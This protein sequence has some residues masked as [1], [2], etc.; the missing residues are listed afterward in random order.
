MYGE[1][2]VRFFCM[3]I[4]TRQKCGFGGCYLCMCCSDFDETK[5]IRLS[6]VGLPMKRRTV[7]FRNRAMRSLFREDRE[8]FFSSHVNLKNMGYSNDLAEVDPAHRQPACAHT[9]RD[10]RAVLFRKTKSK[11]CMAPIHFFL[12]HGK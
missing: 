4:K 2:T 9:R 5:K 1:N 6:G 7:L 3:G 8:N 11:K 12:P 10:P